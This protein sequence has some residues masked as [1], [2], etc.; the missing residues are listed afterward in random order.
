VVHL[1]GM[2]DLMIG[3]TLKLHQADR[4]FHEMKGRQSL[5]NLAA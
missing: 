3:K 4:N 1:N 5:P 2:C